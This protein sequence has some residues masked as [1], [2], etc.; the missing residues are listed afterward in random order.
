MR[1]ATDSPAPRRGVRPWA[2]PA[3]L[4]A[5]AALG[6]GA[7]VVAAPAPP[8]PMP[9]AGEAALL[10]A[11]DDAARLA[12][13]AAALP[14]GA[15]RTEGILS[16][17]AQVLE[18]SL[19]PRWATRAASPTPGSTGAAPTGT[20]STGTGATATASA[21]AS[22]PSGASAGSLARQLASQLAASAAARRADL[23][24]VDGPTAALL[25]SVATGQTLEAE[26]LAP[27]ASTPASQQGS[28]TGGAPTA[29]AGGAPSSD[30][31]SSPAADTP[32]AAGTSAQAGAS[33]NAAETP[34]RAAFEAVQSAE[35][36]AVWAYTVLAARSEAAARAADLA[37]A[38]THRA[39]LGDL[40]ALAGRAAVMLPAPAPGYAL[41]AD[42]G[43]PAQ[44][45]GLEDSAIAAWCALVGAVDP[46]LRASA[47]DGLLESAR[48]AAA[49]AAGTADHG[50]TAS[51]AFPG[52]LAA[53]GAAAH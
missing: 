46:G 37:A 49:L 51:A 5:A 26:R 24:A 43:A 35:Q 1:S 15:S 28:P 18:A 44:L 23:E 39:R 33:A 21:S 29:A 32:S 48:R 6:V 10:R 27:A 22:T 38:D 50:T 31:P 8:E 53:Q 2:W 42:A 20:A 7:S 11:H 45:A 4:A 17:Q 41:P 3:A 25:A 19:P 12:Q 16:L 34:E 36:A 30:V 40:G 52:D 9:T 13:T 14:V 47:A